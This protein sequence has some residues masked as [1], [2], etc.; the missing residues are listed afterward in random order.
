MVM[1]P[2]VPDSSQV[3]TKLFTGHRV[4]QQA[5]GD[6][7]IEATVVSATAE[8]CVVS[9]NGFDRSGQA[10]FTCLYETRLGASPAHPPAG[11]ACLVAFPTNSPT[12]TPW[13]I[14]F[15]EWP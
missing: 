4:A 1:M 11:T 3:F 8:V 6:A 13:V 12:R 10:T 15:T 14:A 5:M 2:A 9:I 7:P